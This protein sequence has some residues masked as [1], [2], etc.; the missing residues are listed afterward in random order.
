MMDTEIGEKTYF[1]EII[2]LA[3]TAQSKKVIKDV[4]SQLQNKKFVASLVDNDWQGII[5]YSDTINLNDLSKYHPELHV[6]KALQ[7]DSYVNSYTVKIQLVYNKQLADGIPNFTLKKFVRS[8]DN[9]T[10]KPYANPGNFRFNTAYYKE[11]EQAKW[12]KRTIV[13]LTFK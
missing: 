8:A 3:K 9:T 12:M 13:L 2:D 7:K 4:Y 11:N 5:P 1:I 10:W 6:F